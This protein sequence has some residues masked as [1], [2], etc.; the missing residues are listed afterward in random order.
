MCVFLECWDGVMGV[1]VKEV[2]NACTLLKESTKVQQRKEALD[3]LKS[4]LELNSVL[5]SIDTE[6][7]AELHDTTTKAQGHSPNSHFQS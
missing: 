3:R 7:T 6:T 4:L 1:G 2:Y 5:H